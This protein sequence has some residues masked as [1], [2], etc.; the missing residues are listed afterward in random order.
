MYS[1]Q[2][3]G[4]RVLSS[5]DS[6]GSFGFELDFLSIICYIT[7]VR[8]YQQGINIPLHIIA[9][10]RFSIIV[11]LILGAGVAHLKEGINL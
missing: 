2:T 10:T 4:R 5:K 1:P 9:F 3:C 6:S 8:V 7:K 11:Q